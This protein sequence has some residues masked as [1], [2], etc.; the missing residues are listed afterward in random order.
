MYISIYYLFT[1]VCFILVRLYQYIYIYIYI[2]RGRRTGTLA[3]LELQW[4][5]HAA[6][7][8]ITVGWCSVP[9]P[10]QKHLVGVR[11]HRLLFANN[12]RPI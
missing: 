10:S 8:R 2:Q 5:R 12:V 6:E 3:L 9:E 7:C 4:R 11:R 1:C